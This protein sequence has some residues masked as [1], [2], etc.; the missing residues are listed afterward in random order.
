MPGFRLSLQRLPL[1][2]AMAFAAT[3]SV[4]S[5]AGPVQA[6]TPSFL[7]AR[8]TTWVE[9]TICGSERLSALDLEL[10]TV[11]AH[12]LRTATPQT[13]RELT[14]SQR[15]WWGLR[16][17]CRTQA[18]GQDCLQ[19]LYDERMAQLKARADYSE[20][21][22]TR[23]V[24]LPPEQL[25]AVGEGWSKSLSRYLKAVRACLVEAP[26]PVRW[27]GG[28]WD[29]ASNDQAVTV[30][31]RA[32]DEH[33]WLCTARRNGREVLAWHEAD[34]QAQLPPEGPLFYPGSAQPAGVCGRPVKV[35]DEND[36]HIGWLGPHCAQM[37]DTTVR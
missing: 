2:A 23:N 8:A 32:A 5:P 21:R 14:A 26:E 13:E 36:V 19:R 12:L 7:C 28:A 24:E 18:D 33:T 35:L 3:A 15:R 16:A 11:Y 6:A 27:V 34:E 17:Q 10:A 30:R 1:A 4:L 31:L 37:A 29:A 25:S 22:P 9:K 20:A